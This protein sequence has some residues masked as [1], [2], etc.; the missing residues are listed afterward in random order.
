MGYSMSKSSKLILICGP[1]FS[2]VGV[3]TSY[4]FLTSEHG[5]HHMPDGSYSTKWVVEVKALQPIAITRYIS[6]FQSIQVYQQ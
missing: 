1:R 2:S 4:L 3:H 6:H 5:V